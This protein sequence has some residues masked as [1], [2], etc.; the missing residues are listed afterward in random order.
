MER[1]ERHRQKGKV[2]EQLKNFGAWLI[3]KLVGDSIAERPAA[4]EH[5]YIFITLLDCDEGI[6]PQR[7]EMN[8]NREEDRR[9]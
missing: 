2:E 9:K 4:L 5:F 8:C 7:K 3:A 1:K 6:G